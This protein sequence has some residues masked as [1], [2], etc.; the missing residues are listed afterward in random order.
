MSKTSH[1]SALCA[2]I[3]PELWFPE[4]G[5]DGGLKAMALC[6]TCPLQFACLE[7]AVSEGITYGVWGGTTP[8]ERRRLIASRRRMWRSPNGQEVA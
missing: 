5:G 2:E 7:Y 6:R 3:D 1:G 8:N 4:K